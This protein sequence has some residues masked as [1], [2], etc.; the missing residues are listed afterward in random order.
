MQ[1][2]WKIDIKN[3]NEFNLKIK[4]LKELYLMYRE[5]FQNYLV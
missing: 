5:Y 2:L 4:N 1:Q 3:V